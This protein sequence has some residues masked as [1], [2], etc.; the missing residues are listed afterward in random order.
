MGA[1]TNRRVKKGEELCIA[2]YDGDVEG[3]AGEHKKKA[4]GR[5]IAVSTGQV[6][7]CIVQNTGEEEGDD[8]NEKELCQCGS[9]CCRGYL[10]AVR[11]EPSR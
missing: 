1:F 7:T 6:F 4:S 2:Y 10:A 11:G 9:K 3:A 5:S 8:V